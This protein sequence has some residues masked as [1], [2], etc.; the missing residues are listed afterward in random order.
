[1]DSFAVQIHELSGEGGA[2]TSAPW[3]TIPLGA[4]AEK[5]TTAEREIYTGKSNGDTAM[6]PIPTAGVLT[7]LNNGEVIQTV[8]YSNRFEGVRSRAETQPTS[9]GD[10]TLV[11]CGPDRSQK[12]ASEIEDEFAGF[13]KLPD[14]KWVQLNPSH[15]KCVIQLRLKKQVPSDAFRNIWSREYYVYAINRVAISFP[16]PKTP[17][18]DLNRATDI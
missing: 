3:V 13:G 6:I 12:P 5:T 15:D 10:I 2:P 14:G 4:S 16:R 18:L 17:Q 9:V 7:V 8:S 11:P 1:M